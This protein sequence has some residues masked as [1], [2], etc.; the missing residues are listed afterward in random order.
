MKRGTPEHPKVYDLMEIIKRRRPEVLGY[1]E[2]LWQFT[3]KYTP[4]GDIGLF[5]D[6]RI[7]AA[8][9]WSGRKGQL[10]DAL[11]QARWVDRDDQYRLVIHDWEAHAD[12]VVKK[13]LQRD[14]LNFLSAQHDS[15]NLTKQKLVND[16]TQSPCVETF[17]CLPVTV[18][19]TVPMAANAREEGPQI[20]TPPPLK[21]SD[22]K[23]PA[24]NGLTR[25]GAGLPSELRPRPFGTA[26][27]HQFGD[28][29]FRW[30]KDARNHLG[31]TWPEPDVGVATRVCAAFDGDTERFDAW[32]RKQSQLAKRRGW[33]VMITAAEDRGR[34]DR[35]NA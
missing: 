31:C 5:S 23:R 18:P 4:R 11:V 26:E 28:L 33:G 27:V 21:I 34:R 14:K 9:D 29:L 10:L 32:M 2:L 25:A 30:W 35:A 3:A 19:V 8:C 7:E 24:G 16:Q 1:L 22:L 13:R 12:G 20:V 6:A 17:G 15:A